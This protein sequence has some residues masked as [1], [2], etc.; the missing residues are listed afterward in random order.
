MEFSHKHIIHLI[1]Y[2][3]W[4]SL[5]NLLKIAR[6]TQGKEILIE[7]YNG[8]INLSLAWAPSSISI[9]QLGN[10]VPLTALRGFAMEN[11]VLRSPSQSHAILD[12]CLH[13]LAS[14]SRS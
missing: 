7:V 11:R 4:N 1:S 13:I 8:G 10:I 14:L 9:M 6:A 5:N 2:N 12:R 3:M